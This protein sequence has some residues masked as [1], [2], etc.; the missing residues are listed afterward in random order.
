MEKD[1]FGRPYV[2][3]YVITHIGKDGFRVLADAQQGRNTYETREQ[4]EHA[5]AMRMQNNSLDT[6]NS[7]YGLPLEVRTCRCYPKHFDPMEL[8]FASNEDGD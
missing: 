7:V 6:L 8:Y 1:K 4:A 3:R 5:L 2:I